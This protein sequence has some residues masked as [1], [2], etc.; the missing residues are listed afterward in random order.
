MI[1]DICT[2]NGC[3]RAA[4]ARNLCKTHYWRLWRTGTTDDLVAIRSPRRQKNVEH[5]FWAKVGMPDP[6]TGCMEWLASKKP[7]GYGQFSARGPSE[8][9]HRVSYELLVGPIPDG[10]V[11]DHLCRNRACVRPDHLE[12]VTNRVNGLRGVGPAAQCAR[13]THCV[14]GHPFSAEN[15]AFTPGG[16]RYCKE[17]NRAKARANNRRKAELKRLGTLLVSATS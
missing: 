4:A 11:I 9:A 12:P 2:V 8:Y 7:A 14:H 3:G 1:K 16:K 15:T 6:D 10:L 13:K 5:L 17:C